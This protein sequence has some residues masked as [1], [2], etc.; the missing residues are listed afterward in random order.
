VIGWGLFV[1]K[2][3]NRISQDTTGDWAYGPGSVLSLIAFIQMFLVFVFQVVAAALPT[4]TGTT[5]PASSLAA[6]PH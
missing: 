2:C 6:V 5:P 4:A 1:N 3:F